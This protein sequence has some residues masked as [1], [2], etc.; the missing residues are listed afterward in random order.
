MGHKPFIHEAGLSGLSWWS[1][2]G[3]TVGHQLC[4]PP[5]NFMGCFPLLSLSSWEQSGAYWGWKCLP[6]QSR[7]VVCVSPSVCPVHFRELTAQDCSPCLY[8]LPSPL[9]GTFSL[10]VERVVSS[11]LSSVP[12]HSLPGPGAVARVVS[13]LV[14]TRE[15][16]PRTG[17]TDPPLHFP[18]GVPGFCTTLFLFIHLFIL[19]PRIE[20][21]TLCLWCRQRNH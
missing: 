7:C 3:D 17:H 15:H 9:P 5:L 2:G 8:R 16:C 14:V 21:G 19:V 13:A 4:V 1:E 12:C 11:V 18:S 20:L 10:P 6:Q